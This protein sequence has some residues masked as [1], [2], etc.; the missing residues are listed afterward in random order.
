MELKIGS[1][2]RR[3]RQ[4]RGITQEELA[5]ALCVTAQAVSKWERNEGYPEITLLPDI[6]EYFGVTLDTLCGIDEERK[7][8]EISS[9][10]TATANASYEDGVR[11][12]REGYAKYP[13]S[14]RIK[15]NLAQALLGCTAKWTPPKEVLE[16]VI[17]LY[18]DVISHCSDMQSHNHA[19]SSLIQVFTLAGE[20]EKARQTALKICGKYENQRAFCKIL[21]GEEL[22]SHIQNSIIQTLPDI[23]FMIKDALETNCYSTDEKIL[24]CKKM[25][26]VYRI[27]DEHRNW[28]IGL[29]FSYQLYLRIAVLYMELKNTNEC[30]NALDN[31]ADLAVLTDSLPSD[32]FPDS[33]LLNRKNYQYLYGSASEKTELLMDIHSEP[34]FDD[35]RNTVRYTEILCKLK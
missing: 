12:A 35:I 32:G 33:L 4:E 34:A 11:I 30:L 22:I 21:K 13:H 1:S 31:A 25:I 23:Y 19:V 15:E 5:N 24:L 29:I 16:E 18:E 3:L 6:A 26:E 14:V 28:P 7:Q 10:L 8:K 9:I 17:R 2:L 27:M 20:H